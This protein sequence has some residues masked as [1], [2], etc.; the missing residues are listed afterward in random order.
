M[1]R[2]ITVTL[3]RAA[4]SALALALSA[5][6]L[7]DANE[8]GETPAAEAR[9]ARMLAQ[10]GG[11]VPVPEKGPWIAVV[12]ES[13]V[14]GA[15]AVAEAVTYIRKTLRLPVREAVSEDAAA[16]A[17]EE[18]ANGAAVAVALVEDPA[19]PSLS[20]FPTGQYG[21]VNSAPLATGDEA[22]FAAR[23]RKEFLRG[24]AYTFGA[25]NASGTCVV[26]PAR[27]VEDLDA[28]PMLNYGP[29]TLVA[30]M[31]NAQGRGMTMLR[32]VPYRRAVEEGWAPPP[33]NDFQRAIW[34]AARTQAATNAPAGE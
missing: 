31:K 18:I 25:G 9:R 12:R 8:S 20:V 5:A 15:D 2:S 22:L 10:T 29:E 28:N 26:K 34:D 11:L 1:N 4:L 27:G 7:A 23:V 14:A 30:I 32:S 21:I 6:A 24:V 13:G 16:A 17:R 3:K 19:A 33:T